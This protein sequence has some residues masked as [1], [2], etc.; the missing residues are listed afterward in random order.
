MNS[1]WYKYALLALLLLALGG[2][3]TVLY[4]FTGTRD[5]LDDLQKNLGI[6]VGVLFVLLIMIYALLYVWLQA[7]SDI[8]VPLVMILCFVNSLVSTT[9]LTASI[10]AK[11]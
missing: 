2:A 10:L 4:F 7:E 8:F 11:Q 1:N 5:N 3:G 6:A 9:G